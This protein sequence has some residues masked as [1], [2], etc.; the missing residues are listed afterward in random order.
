MATPRFACAAWG[1][2]EMGL[3]EYFRLAVRLGLPLVEINVSRS[4]PKHLLPDCSDEQVDEV[5]RWARDAGVTI[6][7]VAGAND[8]SSPEQTVLEEQIRQVQRLIDITA[9]LGAGVLRVFCG[10]EG[11]EDVP[12]SLYTRLHYAF[13]RTG[14]YAAAK[15]VTLGIENHGGPTMTGARAARV[16]AGVRSDAVGFT[17]DPANY[18]KLG[19]DPLIALRQTLPWVRYTHWKDVRWAE[20]GTEYCGVGEGELNWRPLVKELL[21]SGFDGYWAIEYEATA[22]VE[23]GTRDSLTYLQRLLGEL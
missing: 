21:A 6:V 3:A 2:R 12:P 8:F 5:A 17:F 4:T 9:R 11:R 1:F 14:E 18:L 20:G 19:I 22:D 10:G 13:G 16:M 15:G 7:A 23:R